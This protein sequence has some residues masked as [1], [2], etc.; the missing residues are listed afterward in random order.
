MVDKR[1]TPITRN[2]I[3][4]MFEETHGLVFRTAYRITGNA[5]D[6]EDVLQQVFLRLL[7]RSSSAEPLD[8][9]ESYLR[10]SAINLSIDAI[11]KRQDAH[12]VPLDDA[13]ELLA[14]GDQVEG[15]LR[16]SLRLALA[17]LTPRAAEVFA[18]RHFEGYKNQ[19]IAGMLGVSQVQIAVLLFRTRKQLQKEMER[20]S[21]A[22]PHRSGARQ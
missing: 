18:L 15:D 22:K 9:Q 2:P 21:T 12:S 20:L 8:N 17:T 16:D 4:R 19:E 10:R 5:A 14:P 6:A 7:R 3:E 1:P 13:P 11:R